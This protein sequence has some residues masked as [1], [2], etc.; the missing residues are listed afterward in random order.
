MTNKGNKDIGND[1]PSLSADFFGGAERSMPK[2]PASSVWGRIGV[3]SRVRWRR[4]GS[5][6]IQC[7]EG[8][9]LRSCERATQES[10]FAIWAHLAAFRQLS[11][12]NEINS[13]RPPAR[14]S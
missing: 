2:L 11:R 10:G 8:L 9:A 4:I 1:Y 7:C 14:R 3:D 5:R 13:K 6:S 12:E